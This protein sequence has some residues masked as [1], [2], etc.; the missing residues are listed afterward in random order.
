RSTVVVPKLRI[1]GLPS[2]SRAGPQTQCCELPISMLATM[3]CTVD[4]DAATV[5]VGFFVL[6]FECFVIYSPR[7]KR[8][9]GPRWRLM[10]TAVRTMTRAAGRSMFESQLRDA[11]NRY[12]ARG[13]LDEWLLWIQAAE[14]ITRVFRAVWPGPLSCGSC[15]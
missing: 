6:P 3:A 2:A 5:A 7:R 4:I 14:S 15:R 11:T 8:W 13:P 1:A 10:E 12:I 9:P